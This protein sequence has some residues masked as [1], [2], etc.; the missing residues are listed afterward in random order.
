MSQ[1]GLIFKVLSF[2]CNS[3]PLNN[4][5]Q[6]LYQTQQQQLNRTG[7]AEIFPRIYLF[8]DGYNS[9]LDRFNSLP[10]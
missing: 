7:F 6:Y 9:F 10:I 5:G 3:V 2:F 4:R 1:P 8:K